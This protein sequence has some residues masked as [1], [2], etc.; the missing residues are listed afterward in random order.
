M[1][2]SQEEPVLDQTETSAGNQGS[3][4]PDGNAQKRIND[5]MSS[6]QKEQNAHEQTRQ[7]VQRLQ[8]LLAELTASSTDLKNKVQELEGARG[9]ELETAQT[10]LQEAQSRVAELESQVANLTADRDRLQFT[11]DNPDLVPYLKILPNTGD[12]EAL[13]QA[14]ETIRNANQRQKEQMSDSA[15]RHGGSGGPARPA[16]GK[17]TGKDVN[18]Y[19]AEAQGNAAEFQRRLNEVKRQLQ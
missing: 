5:L 6:W 12:T 4:A 3:P 1:S 9:G 16:P 17:W 8:G 13:K 11:V 18:E 10:S 14:A 2:G 15:P 19:L 7:E